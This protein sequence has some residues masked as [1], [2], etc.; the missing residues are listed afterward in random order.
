MLRKILLIFFLIMGFQTF[1]QAVE[2]II[3]LKD[4]DTEAT[5]EDAA[6]SI[7]KTKQN[8]LSNANGVVTF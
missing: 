3:I 1:S 5:I 8:L 6:V 7:V 2:K 4:K